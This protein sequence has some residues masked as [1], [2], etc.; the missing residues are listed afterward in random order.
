M[1]WWYP[2]RDFRDEADIWLKSWEFAT[3][4]REERAR[5]CHLSSKS[6]TVAARPILPRTLISSSCPRVIVPR[7]EF[8]LIVRPS[9]GDRSSTLGV[10]TPVQPLVLDVFPARV[11]RPMDHLPTC[12]RF[13]RLVLGSGDNVINGPA[14]ASSLSSTRLDAPR[15]P[16]SPRG[17]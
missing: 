9:R 1:V 2:A 5:R 17:S 6:E 13:L 16:G 11:P 12:L 8:D 14:R 3:A 15:P 10:P 7:L 4:R